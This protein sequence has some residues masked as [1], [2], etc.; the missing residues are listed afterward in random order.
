MLAIGAMCNI[1]ML[2]LA[3]ISFSSW[4]IF[5]TFAYDIAIYSRDTDFGLKMVKQTT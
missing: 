4:S 5:F 2:M 3:W 1:F